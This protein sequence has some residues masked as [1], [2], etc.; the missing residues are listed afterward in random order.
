MWREFTR[1]LAAGWREIMY[2]WDLLKKE[3]NKRVWRRGEEWGRGV[4]GEGGVGRGGRRSGEE[5][6]GGG[7]GRKSG[8]EGWGGVI[9]W[10][11]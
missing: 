8:E 11:C 3:I 10:G 4:G 6:W 7:V 5:E 9:E 1:A 2:L